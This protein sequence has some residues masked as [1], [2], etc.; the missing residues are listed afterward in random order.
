MPPL[1]RDAWPA[2]QYSSPYA[3]P[4]V[5]SPGDS[6]GQL[7]A[8]SVSASVSQLTP[9]CMPAPTLVPLCCQGV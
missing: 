4:V 2:G 8:E 3:R 7:R 6:V 1:Y 9:A 5:A